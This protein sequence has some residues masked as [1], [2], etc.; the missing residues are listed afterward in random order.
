MKRALVFLSLAATA[1]SLEEGGLLPGDGG[2]PPIDATTNDGT[3]IPDSSVSDAPPS[4]DVVVIPDANDDAPAVD[5]GPC[6][7]PAAACVGVIPPWKVVLFEPNTA[8][9][10]PASWPKSDVATD[11]LPQ[12]GACACTC[13]AT[14][15][16]CTPG[17]LSVTDGANNACGGGSTT[18]FAYPSKCTNATLNLKAYLSV[19]KIPPTGGSCTADVITSSGKVSFT[20]ARSCAAP[21]ACIGDVCAGLVPAGFKACVDSPGDVACSVPGFTNR[22]V[23]GGGA[24]ATCAVG[25]C[26]CGS[27]PTCGGSVE[28]FGQPNCAV[29]TTTIPAD[30]TCNPGNYQNG[31]SVQSVRYQPQPDAVCSGSGAPAPDAKLSGV[32]TICCK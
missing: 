8:L 2:A 15:P 16:T 14:P 19:T 20:V 22:T 4:D 9:G 18:T 29:K 10:C 26:A 7:T 12:A 17:S 21:Q 27:N 6:Q 30:E 31:S 5:A 1:C 28:F 23:V 13:K 32:H 25:T 11:P 3:V 24:S